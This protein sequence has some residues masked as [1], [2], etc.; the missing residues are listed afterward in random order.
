MQQNDQVRSEPSGTAKLDNPWERR[1]KQVC[2]QLPQRGGGWPWAPGCSNTESAA[3]Q[4]DSELLGWN[5][6]GD[7]G[8]TWKT[9][10]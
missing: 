3:T 5:Q 9:Q 4:P 7:K 10:W 2:S 8:M 6:P 1:K